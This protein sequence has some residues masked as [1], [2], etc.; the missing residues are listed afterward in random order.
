MPETKTIFS[1]GMPS[2]GMRFWTADEDRVVTATGA[3]TDLLVGDEVLAGHR[4]DTAGP[5]GDATFEWDVRRL[6]AQPSLSPM[7]FKT[8]SL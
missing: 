5:F 4:A 3:P 2:V 8:G 1:R 7:L 6:P